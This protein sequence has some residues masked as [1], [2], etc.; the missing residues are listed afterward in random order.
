MDME[1]IRGA[2]AFNGPGFIVSADALISEEEI[3]ALNG[4]F[5]GRK[6]NEMNLLFKDCP[7]QVMSDMLESGQSS[8]TGIGPSPNF[9][10]YCGRRYVDLRK[11]AHLS[12]SSEE[13]GAYSCGLA[14]VTELMGAAKWVFWCDY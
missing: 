11:N 3:T 1:T 2:L 4:L 9:S 12:R 10:E 5:K 7:V 6:T 14:A 8:E 13:R